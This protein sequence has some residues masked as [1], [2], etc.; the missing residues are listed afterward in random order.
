MKNAWYKS[1]G[2]ENVRVRNVW[3]PQ[4]RLNTIDI[5]CVSEK[6]G[7]ELFAMTLSTVN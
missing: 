4:A 5:H 3:Y 6:H 1:P 2:Y 7:V